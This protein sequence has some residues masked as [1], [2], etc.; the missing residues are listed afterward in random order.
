[1]ELVPTFMPT[2]AALALTSLI[3][4][5][6]NAYRGGKKIAFQSFFFLSG[7]A[8]AMTYLIVKQN[9]LEQLLSAFAKLSNDLR[10]AISVIVIVATYF[11]GAMYIGG[12][13]GL[14]YLTS[15]FVCRLWNGLYLNKS[16]A[17]KIISPSCI[18]VLIV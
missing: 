9:E 3:F 15:I 1:M 18:C 7:L 14:N 10:L 8:S 13:Q 12:P 17:I 2:L 6:S 16:P 4:L 5:V 11:G